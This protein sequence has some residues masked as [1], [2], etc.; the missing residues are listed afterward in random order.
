MREYG[1]LR[2]GA[3]IY[4]VFGTAHPADRT[5]GL[6]RYFRGPGGWHKPPVFAAETLSGAILEHYDVPLLF[7]A[8]YGIALGAIP[9]RPEGLDYRDPMDDDPG[10]ARRIA[11]ADDLPVGL[12]G[13]RLAGTDRPGS[14]VDLVVFGPD[15]ESTGRA[16][17]ERHRDLGIPRSA[18]LDKFARLTGVPATHVGRRNVF[19]ARCLFEGA[20]VKVDIHYSPA[21]AVTRDRGLPSGEVRAEAVVD[22]LEVLDARGRLYFPGHLWCRHPVHGEVRVWI[23]DH[24]LQF[25]QPGDTLTVLSRVIDSEDGVDL[26]GVDLVGLRTRAGRP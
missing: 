16:I 24:T 5:I 22:G 21:D 3:A 6:L 23:L 15:G 2:T 17:V 14:D 19:K 10:I 25:V 1:M 7:P 4:R 11:G 12:T 13:S 18:T 8:Q 26:I 20:P 9:D